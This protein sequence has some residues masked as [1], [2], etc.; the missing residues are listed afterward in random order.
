M[1][2]RYLPFDAGAEQLKIG[3]PRRELLGGERQVRERQR[4][5]KHLDVNESCCRFVGQRSTDVVWTTDKFG[6]TEIRPQ[7]QASNKLWE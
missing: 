5:R 6:P 1:R 4:G 2:L 3:S 7:R